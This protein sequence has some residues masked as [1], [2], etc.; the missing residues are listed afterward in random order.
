[1][2]SKTFH[3]KYKFSTADWQQQTY[4]NMLSRVFILIITTMIIMIIKNWTQ[5][6]EFIY[7]L[8]MYNA[9]WPFFFFSFERKVYKLNCYFYQL[10]LGPGSIHY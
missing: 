5:D 7:L 2:Y 8:E 6:M 10:N 1:M 3:C 9:M 4:A